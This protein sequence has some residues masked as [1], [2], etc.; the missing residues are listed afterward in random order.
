M[1]DNL[2]AHLRII[3]AVAAKDIADALKNRVIWSTILMVVL[4]VAFYKATP[5][6]TGMA[7]LPEVDVYDAGES[8]L[9]AYLQNSP[10]LEARRVSTKEDMVRFVTM[11]GVP[12]LGL[13][14]PAGFDQ[15][16]A[17]GAPPQLDGYVQ[18]WVNTQAAET[19][20]TQVEEEIAVLMGQE[21]RIQL[22]GRVYPPLDSMGPHS[23]A[24]LATVM[25]LTL[26]GLGL[27]PQL[28]FEEKRSRTLDAL[29]VSPARSGHV[30]AGKAIAGMVYCLV[31]AAVV[32]AFFAALIVQWGFA[33]LA[34][35]LGTLLAVAIGLLFGFTL[36]TV[37]S[38]RMWTLAV[39][40]PLFVLPVALSFMAMDLPAAVNRGVR[41]FPTAA[42]SR[43]LIMSMT[44][45]AP[46]AEWGPDIALALAAAAI[47][48]AVVAW[49]IRR[50]DR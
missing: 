46:L 37:Q 12:A 34:A 15:A 31:G 21:V 47:I 17:S 5:V 26:L 44:D 28:M 42:L 13:A 40:V 24:A 10:N 16:A 7:H 30:V 33:V 25:M 2:R 45:S 6:I 27:T 50:S 38:L 3:W 41:W 9:T 35:M 22:A 18:H 14:I 48:L 36:Q 1:S 49:R 19:L 20:K 23:W 29:L 39:V 43:L 4:M 8:A 32:F 11:E